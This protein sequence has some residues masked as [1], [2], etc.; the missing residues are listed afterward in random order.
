M[1][2]LGMIFV[3]L[4]VDDLHVIQYISDGDVKF[5]WSWAI[6]IMLEWTHSHS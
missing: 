1:A 2:R 4:F 3:V 5:P 6:I